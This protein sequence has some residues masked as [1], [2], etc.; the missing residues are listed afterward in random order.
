M[1]DFTQKNSYNIDDL[2]EIVRLLRGKNGC[3]WDMEQTH[4]SIKSD[5]IEEVC[6]AIEAIDLKDTELL[7]EELGDV[8]LQV[9]FHCQIETENSN[10]SFD[11]ICDG[12]CKKMI[13]R[14][15]HVFGSVTVADSGEVLKNWDDIKSKEKKFNTISEEI[16]A[17]ANALPALLKAHKVQ[18]KAARV[19]FDFENTLEA[20]AKVQEELNEILTEYNSNNMERIIDEVGDLLFACVNLARLL[21]VD[22]EEALN[23]ASKKFAIRFKYVEDKVLQNNKSMKDV[24]IDELNKFWDEAKNNE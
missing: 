20:A 18:K 1:V 5:F 12:I 14:H 16:D 6:E 24:S 17:I 3:P 15:P 13:V 23:K 19:G 9:V 11:D 22:E 2:I 4:E 10:F 21:K 7:K 8:L